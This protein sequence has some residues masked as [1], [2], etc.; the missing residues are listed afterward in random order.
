MAGQH[1]G[2]Q[3]RCNGAAAAQHRAEA[4]D[5]AA[6]DGWDGPQELPAGGTAPMQAAHEKRIATRQGWQDRPQCTPTTHN[7]DGDGQ[8][9]AE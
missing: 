6:M 7:R 2:Y 4:G 8:A 3:H 9:R 5:G 1:S